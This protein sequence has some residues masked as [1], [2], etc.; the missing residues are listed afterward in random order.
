VAQKIIGAQRDFSFGEV[1]TT[2]KRNDDHPARKG[3]LRQMAN[4]R[5]L[6][7]GALQNRPGRRALFASTNATRIEEFSMSNGNVFKIAFGASPTTGEIRI[8]NSAGVQVA[9][10]G[11]GGHQQLSRLS[12]L[13]LRRS[14]PPRLLQFP[15][16][17]RRHRWS[18]INS[19]TDLYVGA[20][21]VR[22]HVRIAP[23]RCRSITSCRA[24]KFGVRVLRP[25]KI[26]YIPI[27]PTNPLKPGSVEFQ[28]L[29]GDG[30]RRCSRGSRRRQSFTPTPGRTA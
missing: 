9:G 24:G 16:D 3:G 4:A 11:R 14:V 22:R 21:S 7:S 27:S 17:P 30:A 1:D 10:V 25:R 5:I 13:V 20:E 6:N 23:A 15:G 28:L 19:P 29:S 2:L 8:Y 12:G 26:Y 18:A